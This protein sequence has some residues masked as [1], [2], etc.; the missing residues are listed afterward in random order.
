MILRLYGTGRT[1]CP[2]DA[3]WETMSSLF[4]LYEST[5][6]IIIAEIHKVQTSCGYGVPIYAFIEE[7][8]IHFE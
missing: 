8:N 2:A 1:V 7:R 4:T 5:R 6:Q 3:E